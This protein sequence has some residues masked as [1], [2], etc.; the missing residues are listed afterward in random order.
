MLLAKKNNRKIA[1]FRQSK[2]TSADGPPRQG[3]HLVG[4]TYRVCFTLLSP[5]FLPDEHIPALVGMRRL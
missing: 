1:N 3:P 5:F 4:A 2:P